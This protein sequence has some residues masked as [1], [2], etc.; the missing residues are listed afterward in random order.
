M[1]VLPCQLPD[2]VTSHTLGLDG[3]ERFDLELRGDVRPRQ[4]ARL[5]I[6]RRDGR[7]DSVAL[8][9]RI[10]TPIEAAYF[11][12]GGILPYVLERLLAKDQPAS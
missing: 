4:P 1:G 6:Q 7:R 3:T 10:D 5:H 12:A 8:V 2:G 11:A 9:I